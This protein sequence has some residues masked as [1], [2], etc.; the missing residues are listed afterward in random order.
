[1]VYLL[2]TLA[3]RTCKTSVCSGTITGIRAN[4]FDGGQVPR[5]IRRCGCWGC[6][7]VVDDNTDVGDDDVDDNTVINAP[8]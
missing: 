6:D 8:C 1:M 7:Y 5:A 2:Q 4:M 3:M